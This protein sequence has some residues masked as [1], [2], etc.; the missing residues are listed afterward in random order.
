MLT[1]TM[2]FDDPLFKV[3]SVTP[4]HSKRKNGA[5]HKVIV[6][7]RKKD[8]KR[9]TNVE[10]GRR[11]RSTNSKE[12]RRAIK[13]KNVT[14]RRSLRN[15]NNKTVGEINRSS[16]KE[17]LTLFYKTYNPSKLD[18]VDELLERYV[19]REEEMFRR[20][21]NKYK[22][23]PSVFG[24]DGITPSKIHT[25]FTPQPGKSGTASGSPVAQ[26]STK[27]HPFSSTVT[28][29]S[30]FGVSNNLSKSSYSS[31]AEA[32]A[33]FSASQSLKNGSSALSFGSLAA[34]SFRS[35]ATPSFS[36]LAATKASS[37]SGFQSL[38]SSSSKPTTFAAVWGQTI[39]IR[40]NRSFDS[41]AI[42]GMDCD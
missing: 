22:A 16:N 23:D 13:E 8:Y 15:P 34:P 20:L 33:S 32:S 26:A 27:P 21:L 3:G 29:V 40:R 28:P 7:K 35:L 12:F 14:N 41:E 11:R 19:G 42:E 17:K 24:L 5:T 31:F 4:K 39:N 25:P 38:S 2:K 18:E 36:S 9:C 10:E 1:R 30:G 6:E 37:G